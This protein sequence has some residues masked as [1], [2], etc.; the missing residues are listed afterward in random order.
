MPST[1][2]FP[3]TSPHISY[4]CPH[5]FTYYSLSRLPFC[6]SAI[7]G[8]CGT[9]KFVEKNPT[10]IGVGPSE[11]APMFLEGPRGRQTTRAQGGGGKFLARPCPCSRVFIR[12]PILV[13]LYSLS[14]QRGPPVRQATGSLS[15]QGTPFQATGS[16]VRTRGPHMPSD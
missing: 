12:S 11:G 4:P 16:A 2:R 1:L 5:I 14:G 8:H 10:P 7:D 15:I 6:L 9:C 3:P 13:L